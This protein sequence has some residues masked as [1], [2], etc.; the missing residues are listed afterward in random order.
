MGW[1]RI[2]VLGEAV[3]VGIDIGRK[4][5]LGKLISLGE[6]D[7]EGYAALTKPMHEVKV[8]LLG[9]VAAVDEHE[10]VCKGFALKDITGDHLLELGSLGFAALG[11]TVAGEVNEIP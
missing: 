1:E 7:A 2:P 10:E 4:G 5:L 8:D 9:F 11:E 6:D 3:E